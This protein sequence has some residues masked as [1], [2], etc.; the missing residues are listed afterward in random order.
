[1]ALKSSLVLQD[2]GYKL[3]LQK[4]RD[5]ELWSAKVRSPEAKM[6]IE[7]ILPVIFGLRKSREE[8]N[9]AF[10][11]LHQQVLSGDK[12]RNIPCPAK[13]VQTSN[14]ETQTTILHETSL[15]GRRPP[16]REAGTDTPCWWDLRGPAQQQTAR[17]KGPKTGRVESSADAGKQPQKRSSVETEKQSSAEEDSPSQNDDFTLVKKRRKKNRKTKAEDPAAAKLQPIKEPVGVKHKRLP[18]TQAVVLDKPTGTMTYADMVREVKT[19]ASQEALSFEITSRRAKSGNLIL[20]TRDKEHAD[21]LANVLKRKFGEGKGIRRPSPS[22]ALLLIGI[23][24]SVDPPELKSILEAHDSELKL[25]NE[26]V[27]REGLNGVRTTIVR[28]PLSPGLKLARLKKIRIGWATC[29]VKEL[30]AKQGC[31]RCFDHGHATAAC[32]GKEGRR[33]FRCKK[34]GHLIASCELPSTEKQA[35]T[36]L[37]QRAATPGTVPPTSP[38]P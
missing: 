26:I 2:G 29:R 37:T 14:S 6:A 32:T 33:C 22:I 34:I 24:D 30:V 10:N 12:V 13:L 9:M 18:R 35:Q 28:V 36:D 27:I 7:A 15:E 8:V 17:R 5:L 25:S 3:L 23:E 31:A 16:T 38:C 4:A 11:A 1:M 20:E 21:E 19:V